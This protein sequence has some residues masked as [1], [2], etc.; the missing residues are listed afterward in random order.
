MG[1]GVGEEGEGVM[2]P[3]SASLSHIRIG[4]RGGCVRSQ[5]H[6]MEKCGLEGTSGGPWCNPLLRAGQTSKF[7]EVP[8]LLRHRCIFPAL[9][10]PDTAGTE[11]AA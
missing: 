8:Q 6:L 4:S 3:L 10:A 9:Q 11:H 1:S 5:L 7:S 2:S